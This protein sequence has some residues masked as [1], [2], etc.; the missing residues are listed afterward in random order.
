MKKLTLVLLIIFGIFL[1]GCSDNYEI[2]KNDFQ[3]GNVKEEVRSQENELNYYFISENEIP[4]GFS[5]ME[6][7]EMF[8]EN[9]G[10][11]SKQVAD[12]FAGANQQTI[13]TPDSS[14]KNF[15]SKVEYD[16]VALGIY[17]PEGS[18]EDFQVIMISK[19]KESSMIEEYVE[20]AKSGLS[21]NQ[22]IYKT[23][24]NYLIVIDGKGD[25][26]TSLNTIY[27]NKFELEKLN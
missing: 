4:Q 26:I 9:P 22:G 15:D 16:E 14:A 27:E 8:P 24:E 1:S 23:S 18:S 5:L 13:A 20:G 2:E 21:P 17:L 25:F 12:I 19:L 7:N 3:E 11:V 6:T 10:V